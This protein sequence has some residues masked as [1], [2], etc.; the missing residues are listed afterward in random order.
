[1]L[2]I[3]YLA[4]ALMIMCARYIVTSLTYFHLLTESSFTLSPVEATTMHPQAY[5][6]PS[7][8]LLFSR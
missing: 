3:K 4:Q 2:D 6:G 5:A 8:L 7:F 1:M